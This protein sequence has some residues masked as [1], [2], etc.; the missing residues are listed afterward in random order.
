MTDEK[1]KEIRS[2]AIVC[3]LLIGGIYLCA[4]DKDWGFVL[5][6]IAIFWD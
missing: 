5:L 3:T 4:H 2:T 1:V 6:L